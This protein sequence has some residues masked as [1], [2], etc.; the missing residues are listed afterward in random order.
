MEFRFEKL[1]LWNDSLR[2]T[3]SLF[4]LSKILKEKKYYVIADQLGRAALS[5]TNNIAEGSGSAS[6]RDFANFLNM[7][8]RSVYECVNLLHVCN[9]MGL[10]EN[11]TKEDLRS[12]LFRISIMIHALRKSLLDRKT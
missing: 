8:K 12:K 1:D 11:P 9:R 6:S 2:I 3:E 5:I 4:E 7:S 10:I